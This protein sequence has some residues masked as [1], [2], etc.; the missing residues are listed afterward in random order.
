LVLHVLGPIVAVSIV[1]ALPIIWRAFAE[2]D[3]GDPGKGVTGLTY[4]ANVPAP[5]GAEGGVSGVL[6]ARARL[7]IEAG[8][9]ESQ[10]SAY[11]L[12]K[13]LRCGM[14]EARAVRDALKEG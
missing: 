7:L 1:T 12:Q 6:V 8:Q 5:K 3:H 11:R 10:P 4:R 13:A 9:V 14:N 2:L